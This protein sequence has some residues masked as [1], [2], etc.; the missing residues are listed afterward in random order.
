MCFVMTLKKKIK[1][2]QSEKRAGRFFLGVFNHY[3]S[4]AFKKKNFEFK[5]TKS[6]WFKKIMYF[7]Y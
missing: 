7:V 6:H 3:V 2:R 5:A 4:W 1:P